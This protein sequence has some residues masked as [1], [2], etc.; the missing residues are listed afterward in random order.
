MPRQV[1]PALDLRTPEQRRGLTSAQRNIQAITGILQTLGAG[2]QKRREREK[3][4]RI[5][6]AIAGG[7][8]NIEAIAEIARQE[9]EL[10]TGFQGILQRIGGAFQPSPGGIQRGIS[11]TIIG[12]RLRQALTPKTEIPEGLEPST[13][14]VSP[15]GGVTRRFA[16][17]EKTKI[18][19][20]TD[21]G[22]SLEEARMIRDISHGLKPRASTRKQYDNMNDVEKMSFLSTLKQ[23]AEGQYYGVEGGNIEPRQPK[24]LKW[25]N[26][27]LGGLSILKSGAPQA[28]ERIIEP[29][30]PPVE[31]WQLQGMVTPEMRPSPEMGMQSAPDMRLD[32]IWADLS[33]EQ[34]EAVWENEDKVMAALDNG[35]TIEQVLEALGE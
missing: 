31:D 16:R 11:E 20:L 23:R 34:K 22:Y 4:D 7:A 30:A 18:K 35:Y 9:P 2:E 8:T 14:T 15:T 13:A 25:V 10:G 21:E 12:A 26:E 17:P 28:P 29:K 1:L 3:L 5:V 32:S 6:R 33:T 24:L 27:E 19:E